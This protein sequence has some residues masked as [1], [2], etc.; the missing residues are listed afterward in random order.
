MLFDAGTAELKP[1]TREILEALFAAIRP[2][3]ADKTVR[4]IR[5]EGHTDDTP[6]RTAHFP[7][8]WRKIV[9][10]AGDERGAVSG[11]AAPAARA[12]PGGGGLCRHPA[13]G[14]Q[15][16]TG[17]RAKT[18][19]SRSACSRSRVFEEKRCQTRKKAVT[20]RNRWSPSLPALLLMGAGTFFFGQK[21]GGGFEKAGKRAAG[22]R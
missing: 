3:I 12:A 10:H 15:R 13:R 14:A 7:S 22:Y 18:G 11:G 2:E 17:G 20:G 9:H 8:N 1:R 4:K 19:A 21:V 5:V 16:H 6:I